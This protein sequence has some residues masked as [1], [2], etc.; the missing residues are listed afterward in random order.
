MLRGGSPHLALLNYDSGTEPT[1]FPSLN[2]SEHLVM[3]APGARKKE[4]RKMADEIDEDRLSIRQSF[5]S[6]T[7]FNPELLVCANPYLAYVEP[8]LAEETDTDED[9]G[10]PD[11]DAEDEPGLP[12]FG[13]SAYLELAKAEIARYEEDIED[14][15]AKLAGYGK[16]NLGLI[17]AIEQHIR[18]LRDLRQIVQSHES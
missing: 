7:L 15:E 4:N 13:T 10:P 3:T 1:T 6:L 8:E 5:E 14:L 9:E 18:V 12:A 11:P 16:G 2:R 17:D